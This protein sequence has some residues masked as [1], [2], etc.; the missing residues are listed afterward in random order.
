MKDARITPHRASA[1]PPEVDAICD[2]FEAAWL[3]GDEPQ[4]DEFLAE[5]NSAQAEVLLRELLLC[6]WELR[7]RHGQCVDVDVY[8]RRL[9]NCGRVIADLWR[10]WNESHSKS[11][12]NGLAIGSDTMRVTAQV[13]A[14]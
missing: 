8:H 12:S 10:D 9:P 5:G 11:A 7:Q 4:I 6:E 14:A 3:A 1:P 13:V 2:A